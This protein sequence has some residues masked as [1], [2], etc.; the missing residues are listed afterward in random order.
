[1][2]EMQDLFDDMRMPHITVATDGTVLAFAKLGRLLRRSEDGGQTWTDAQ[3]VGPDV[4]GASAIVDTHTGDVLLVNSERAR[5]WRSGDHG[6][7]WAGEDIVIK[8]NAAGHGT[9][10]GLPSQTACSSGSA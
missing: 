4:G 9:P 1:M 6:K 5:L 8:P 2:F 7:T 10:D 3:E